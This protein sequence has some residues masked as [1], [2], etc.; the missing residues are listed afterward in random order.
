[1]DEPIRA[2]SMPMFGLKKRTPEELGARLL[3]AQRGLLEFEAQNL[4]A[5]KRSREDALASL[6]LGDDT[7]YGH[8]VRRY[9]LADR[10]A[11]TAKGM[12]EMIHGL[13]DVLAV[14]AGLKQVV[15]IGEEMMR[16]QGELDVKASALDHALKRLRTGMYMTDHAAMQVKNVIKSVCLGEANDEE[17]RVVHEELLAQLEKE[18]TLGRRVKQELHHEATSAGKD[19]GNGP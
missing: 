3:E 14:Q 12:L 6:R 9:S 5:A 7:G 8:A 18:T 17:L 2:R 4:A 10:Q 1:M 15:S 16:V 19:V 13:L 11:R